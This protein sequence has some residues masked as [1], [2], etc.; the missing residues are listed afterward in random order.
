MGTLFTGILSIFAA[1]L[2]CWALLYVAFRR[3]FVFTIGSIFLAV[4]DMVA[5]FGFI[6]GSKG[7][8]HILWAAPIAIICIL[9]SYS[10]LSKWIKEPIQYLTGIIKAVS[11]KDLTVAIDAKYDNKK[12]EIKDIVLSMQELLLSQKELISEL[13]ES[14]D[15]LLHT[16]T[17][18]NT[19]STSLSTGASEQASGLEEISSSIE[20]MTASIHSNAQNALD[21]KEISEKSYKDLQLLLNKVDEAVQAMSRIHQEVTSISAIANQTNI[22]ALNASI[23][24]AKAGDAGKGFGVVATEVRKLAEQSSVSASHITDITAVGVERIN[25]VME[26]IQHLNKETQKS[27]SLVAEVA[28]A[29]NEMKIGASQVNAAVQELNAV[30][31]DNASSSEELSATSEVLLDTSKK[32]SGIVKLYSYN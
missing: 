13:G 30:V 32:F 23:E 26:G 16:S 6:L 21:S 4:I 5:I 18:V 24:A 22:L 11:D 10:L 14:A 25:E 7:L 20:E 3:T 19:S 9:A 15:N 12:H 2:V 1:G 31:Q 8:I 17:Q 27:T 28:A 29:T